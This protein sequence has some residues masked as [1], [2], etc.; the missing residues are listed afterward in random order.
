MTDHQH[1]ISRLK[2]GEGGNSDL[3]RAICLA[4]GFPPRVEAPFDAAGRGV[5]YW[6]AITYSLD[7]AIA[8]AEGVLPGCWYHIAKGKLR[9]AEPLFGALI[10][11]GSDDVLGAGEH[12]TSLPRA[13]LIATLSA[14]HGQSE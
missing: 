6:T 13:L 5:E 8:F 2:E 11:F 7:A 3:D 12:P 14:L 1:L 9:A 4:A 10:L